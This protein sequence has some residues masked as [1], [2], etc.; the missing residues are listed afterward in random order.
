MLDHHPTR[1][2]MPT[3]LFLAL[4]LLIPGAT[5]A[6]GPAAVTSIAFE[7]AVLEDL[8]IEVHAVPSAASEIDEGMGFA[9]T[10]AL[11][12]DAPG[13][14]FEGFSGGTLTHT[15]ELT[16]TIAGHDHSLSSFEL[17]VA[18]DPM[19]LELFDANGQRWLLFQAPQPFVAGGEL[20]VQ[21]IDVNLA[22][23]LAAILGRPEL[24]GSY[25]GRAHVRVP[26]PLI[27]APAGVTTQ[28]G[29]GPCDEVFTPD[30]DVS[31]ID[32][33]TVIQLAREPGGRV[34]LSFSAQ[35]RNVGTSSILWKEAI[36]PESHVPAHPVGEHPFLTLHVYRIANGR[37]TQVGRSGVKHAF[38]AV[39]SN[40]PCAGAHVIYSGCEDTYGRSTNANRNYL[41]PREEVSAGS[42]DWS[43]L[44]SHFDGSPVDDFRDH[45]NGSSEHD[46]FEHRLL[47]DES[48]LQAGGDYF[49]GAWYIIRDDVDLFNSMGH[50]EILPSFASSTWT[51]TTQTSLVNG[52]ILDE[53][54]DS[55]TLPAGSSNRVVDTGE[56][57][58]QLAVST[59]DLGGGLF[60]YE[61]ALMNFDFDR[62]IDSF[63]L[64]L[65]PGISVSNV[66][67]ADADVDVVNDWTASFG[68]HSITWDAA[69]GNEMDWSTLYSFGFDADTA[70]VETTASIGVF[71]AGAPSG[72]QIGGQGPA[73]PVGVPVHGSPVWLIA[74][75]LTLL[76]LAAYRLRSRG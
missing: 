41:A 56:G 32:I 30:R 18:A 62:Q 7:R 60:R 51:F 71:E 28:G 48:S 26:A 73:P 33:G 63:R 6:S 59:T 14:D 39:N 53:F 20:N 34:A 70:P 50:D 46:D 66:S 11:T 3:S 36:E 37:I 31:L 25:L 64:P 2:A 74:A 23:E 4:L 38:F 47:V 13:G 5:A 75:A 9:G 21:N 43:S 16:L 69:A 19:E 55:V 44:G 76:A 52:S 24:A 49:V 12:F 72:I 10:S 35:L 57:R 68:T 54:V 40:C 22:P 67:F 1:A 17:R 58:L 29:T 61:Y 15:G 45:G 8:G 65:R 27:A 42:G